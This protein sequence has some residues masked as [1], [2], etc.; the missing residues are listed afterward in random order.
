MPQYSGISS[1][2]QLQERQGGCCSCNLSG[3]IKVGPY[4]EPQGHNVVK[5]LS[6]CPKRRHVFAPSISLI[7]TQQRINNQSYTIIKKPHRQLQTPHTDVRSRVCV[8][9]VISSDSEL[10]KRIG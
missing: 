3:C 7:Y 8:H 1:L 9:L 6:D 2:Q 4:H 5:A 10:K